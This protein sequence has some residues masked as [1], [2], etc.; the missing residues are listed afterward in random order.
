MVIFNKRK[1]RYLFAKNTGVEV[2]KMRYWYAVIT[3][4]RGLSTGTWRPEKC[5]TDILSSNL[6]VV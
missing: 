5:L 1:W 4:V 3:F 6:F 2:L